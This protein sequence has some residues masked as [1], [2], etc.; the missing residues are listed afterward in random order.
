MATL[1]RISKSP[2]VAGVSVF[3]DRPYSASAVNLDFDAGINASN[4]WLSSDTASLNSQDD[5]PETAPGKSARV[6]YDFDG[7]AEFRELTVEA[8][9]NLEI[10]DEILPDGWSLVKAEDG[11]IGLLPQSYYT[12]C[13]IAPYPSAG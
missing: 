3:Q 9:D 5:S 1:P 10:I 11:E 2:P 7:K 13:C 4:A 6:L 8:G 12:V